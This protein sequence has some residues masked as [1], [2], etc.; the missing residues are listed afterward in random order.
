MLPA[1][2]TTPEAVAL[3]MQTATRKQSGQNPRVSLMADHCALAVEAAQQCGG[4]G[5]DNTLPRLKHALLLLAVLSSAQAHQ[6]IVI[7]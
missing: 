1:I 3:G 7:I 5:A 6:A 4:T 2:A